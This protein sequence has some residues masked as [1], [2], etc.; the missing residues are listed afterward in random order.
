MW[1]ALLFSI[2]GLRGLLI[3]EGNPVIVGTLT[4]SLYLY[5]HWRL[6]LRRDVRRKIVPDTLALLYG[7]GEWPPSWQQQR[8]DLLRHFEALQSAE[9][10][11]LK[12]FYYSKV[13]K[14]ISL[15]SK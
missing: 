8:H 6:D 1:F 11:A 7:S 14:E 15:I 13:H 2:F 3:G 12:K 10:N 4:V 9:E 5:F